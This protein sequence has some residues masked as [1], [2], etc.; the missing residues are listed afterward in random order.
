MDLKG[1]HMDW[2]KAKNILIV[3]FIITNAFLI[4]NIEQDLYKKNS[5][6]MINDKIIKD[7]V[8]ILNEK[9]IQVDAEVPKKI[10]ALPVLNVEYETYDKY[11]ILKII[12]PKENEK[13]SLDIENNKVIQYKKESSPIVYTDMNAKKAKNM[14]EAFIDQLGFMKRDTV[15]W[16][17][18][19]VDDKYNIMFKQVYKED[20]L[21]CSYMNV[22]VSLNGIEEFERMWLKPSKS[23][24]SKKEI[25]PAT[26]ALLKY[27]QDV[28]ESYEPVVIKDISL[29]YWFDPSQISFANAENIKSGTAVP[30]W[31]IVLNDKTTK[32]I[33]AYDSY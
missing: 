33:V 21:E 2:S 14:A 7:T 32:F 19:K 17:T 23:D 29:G 11:E 20:F 9:N 27:M 25:I 3:A 28:E 24:S 31:R 13:I 10:I 6:V 30:A 15:Y 16:D 1:D 18:K 12:K 4:Y 22:V 8:E 26:K 5:V